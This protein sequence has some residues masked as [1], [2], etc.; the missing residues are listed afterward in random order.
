M[1][2]RVCDVATGVQRFVVFEQGVH[3]RLQVKKKSPPKRAFLLVHFV[4]RRRIDARE[5]ALQGLV[6][7]KGE[8]ASPILQ[9][10]SAGIHITAQP[11]TA[12]NRK[13]RR[14][15]ALSLTKTEPSVAF[16]APASQASRKQARAK[17]Q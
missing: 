11:Q 1:L 10:G 16:D 5:R 9:V 15:R 7:A 8:W 13:A 4:P 12:Q 14:K 6:S 17:Q 2:V 3:L